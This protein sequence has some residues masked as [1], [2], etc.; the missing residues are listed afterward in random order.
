MYVYK[1]SDKISHIYK[2]LYEYTF[3]RCVDIPLNMISIC[4][5]VGDAIVKFLLDLVTDMG[6][7]RRDRHV[8]G[9]KNN[10]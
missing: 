1:F 6:C 10:K 7:D 8:I 2:T 4:V 3:I 5:C 9:E